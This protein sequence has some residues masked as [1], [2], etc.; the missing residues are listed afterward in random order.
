[1]EPRLEIVHEQD[2]VYLSDTIEAP[3][4]TVFISYYELPSVIQRLI[5][6]RDSPQCLEWARRELAKRGTR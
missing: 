3:T 2:G 6:A 1:M 4:D 5:E